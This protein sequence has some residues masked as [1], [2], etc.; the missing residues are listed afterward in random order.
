V[1]FRLSFKVRGGWVRIEGVR[2][3]RRSAGTPY[4]SFEDKVRSTEYSFEGVPVCT[5]A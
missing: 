5:R 3:L 1:W 2:S 4:L